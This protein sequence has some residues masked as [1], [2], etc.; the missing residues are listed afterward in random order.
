LEGKE[1][2]HNDIAGAM[3]TLRLVEEGIV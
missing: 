1:E 3:A 2:N